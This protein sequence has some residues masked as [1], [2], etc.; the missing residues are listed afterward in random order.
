MLY[1]VYWL[2]NVVPFLHSWNETY[3]I[4]NPKYNLSSWKHCSKKLHI[5]EIC[6]HDTQWTIDDPKITSTQAKRKHFQVSKTKTCE[7]CRHTTHR[8][9]FF[10]IRECHDW[11]QGI[12]HDWY[13]HPYHT[14]FLAL[15]THCSV[16]LISN[17]KP[18][19]CDALWCCNCRYRF[20]TS[21]LS[22]LLMIF[23]IN[24][25]TGR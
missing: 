14:A 10:N 20:S 22:C 19:S 4:M 6:H 16:I 2:A 3:L 21:G 9:F 13:K 23:I 7:W 11:W 12:S 24:R 8:F 15:W 1:Y 5:S 18:L 25:V 17:K